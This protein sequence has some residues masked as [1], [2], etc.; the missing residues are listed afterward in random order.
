MNKQ[1]LTKLISENLFQIP[2]YQRGYAWEKKQWDDFI[3]DL[4]ALADDEVRSHYT[5]TVV[6]YANARQE[7]KPYGKTKKL[8]VVDVVDGQ[9][10]LTTCSLYLS[11]IIRALI[12]HGVDDYKQELPIYLYAGS[13]T[14]LLLNNDCQNIFRSLLEHG[15]AATP[16]HSTH[17]HRLV[18]ACTYLKT[19]LDK[20]LVL[21]KEAGLDYLQN[22]FNAITQK[23]TFTYYAIEEA[24][25]IGMTFELMN[26]R[27]KDLSIL[28]LLKNYLMH[29][30]SRNVNDDQQR[31][32]LTIHINQHWKDT[33][34]NLG[35]CNGDEDQCLHVAWT[36]YC[37]RSPG[38]WDGY[39][40]FKDVEY[41]PLRN[42]TKRSKQAVQD[43]LVKF[44]FELANISRHYAQIMVPSVATSLA[45]EEHIWLQKLLNAGNIA[46]FLPI[47]IAARKKVADG[48]LV[49]DEYIELLKALECY[50]YR[51]FLFDGRR[52]N[53]GKSSLYRLGSELI[54]DTTSAQE[55]TNLVHKIIL[56]YSTQ[57]AFLEWMEK[58]ADWYAYRR[59]LRYTLFEYEL[60]LLKSEG[61]GKRPL[62]KWQDLNDSSVEHILPQT[63]A[64]GS[65]WR[66][67]W[68][69]IEHKVCVH[70]IGNLVLTQNNANYLNFDFERKKGKAGISPSYINSDIRQERRISS[71][72]DWTPVEFNA[73]RQELVQWIAE[74]WQSRYVSNAE[75]VELNDELDAEVDDDVNEDVL[76]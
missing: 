51:V 10:R 43:F 48:K 68:S 6:V 32:D 38:N 57:K 64:K 71:H 74:R 49:K 13:T 29:W 23:L 59:L 44:S 66:K 30:I 67:V 58:P 61:K 70:D 39:A 16:P 35:T 14:R 19:H 75:A 11:V 53:A 4:D 33:Y 31:V 36:L 24:C 27:G 50:A 41:I 37:S 42:F 3:Q 18:Q 63:P 7:L 8:A 65:H 62:L 28:E 55:V 1:T 34:T 5:G 17:Q 52:S 60:H 54:A 46:N 56:R 69:E 20:Q 45:P 22:L 73:R 12:A 2:D 21:R 9:Q 26:S 76:A 47:M 72:E 40:G 15:Q 25:E